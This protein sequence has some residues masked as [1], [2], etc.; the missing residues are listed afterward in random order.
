MTVE[1]IK[2]AHLAYWRHTEGCWTTN[3]PAQG[4]TGCPDHNALYAEWQRQLNACWGVYVNE[5]SI[6]A[7]GRGLLY[8]N[9]F[10]K[11]RTHAFEQLA[12]AEW[13]VMCDSEQDAMALKTSM[14]ADQGIPI[15]ALKMKTY[16]QCKHLRGA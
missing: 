10:L 9:E 15:K 11:Y 3:N 4:L 7:T 12:P 6:R 16:G 14:S 2:Q 8:W 5:S 1:Q 13:F